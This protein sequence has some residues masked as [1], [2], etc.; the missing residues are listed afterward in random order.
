MISARNEHA[1]SEVIGFILIIVIIITAFSLYLTYAVPAQGRENEIKHMD[2]I[3]DELVGYKI[4]VDSL[5]TNRQTESLMSTTI[6]MGTAGATTQGSNGFLPIIQPVGS[7]GTVAIN[8]RTTSPEWLN[9]SS[10][11]YITNQSSKTN[12]TP[13]RITTSLQSKTYTDPP[14]NLVVNISVMKNLQVTN[15]SVNLSGTD[16]N[17]ISWQARINVTPRKTFYQTYIAIL[18]G[19]ATCPA[20]YYQN[21]TPIWINNGG[22]ANRLCLVPMNQYNYTGTDLTLT[23]YKNK[24]QSLSDVIVYDYITANSFYEIDLLDPVFGLS[25]NIQKTPTISFMESDSATDLTVDL[26][27]K[28]AYQFQPK[29]AFNISLGALEYRADNNYW[30]PQTYYYQMGGIFLS[31]SD[32]VSTKVPPSITFKY[33]PSGSI[34]INILGISIGP[35]NSGSIGGTSPIQIGTKVR[36]DSGNLPY[37]PITNNTMNVTINFTSPTNDA[38]TILMWKQY[39]QDAANR[40]GGIPD[41]NQFYQVGTTSNSAY[42]VVKGVYDPGTTPGA[43]ANTPDIN[44]NVQAVNLSARI[45]SMSGV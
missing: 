22:G 16:Q 1:L 20:A 23:L 13:L 34:R 24:T 11:S 40:T 14:N 43:T 45:Q 44:L 37:A 25:S 15:C 31:Q 8:Q 9:I 30:I 29:Y 12:D 10:Y 21:G 6:K 3:K 35:E 4:G 38:N 27:A 39:F 32:G 2:E 36:S 28:Y 19:A 7:S 26:I 17:G 18:V 41:N 33:N 5:W 42:I